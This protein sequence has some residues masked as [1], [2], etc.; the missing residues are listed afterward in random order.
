MRPLLA[1]RLSARASVTVTLRCCSTTTPTTSEDSAAAPSTATRSARQL[2]L[3]VVRPDLLDDWVPELNDVIAQE[4]SCNEATTPV[5]WRCSHCQERYQCT[6]QARV[7]RGRAACPRCGGRIR[8]TG[9]PS[10]NNSTSLSTAPLPRDEPA[11]C[12]D[13]G[14]MLDK[15]HPDLA[16][17][18]D[19]TRNGRLLPSQVTASSTRQVWWLPDASTAPPTSPSAQ[20][21]A[22]AQ[23]SF[24]RPVFAFV[25]DA[26]SP[27][28]Q[29]AATAAMEWRLLHE[30]RRVAHIEDAEKAG[31]IPIALPS[32]PVGTRQAA[33][34]LTGFD[35]ASDAV[36]RPPLAAPMAT[37][38]VHVV[39]CMWKDRISRL[40]LKEKITDGTSMQVSEPCLASI[41]PRELFSHSPTTTRQAGSSAHGAAA[42]AVREA[43]LSQY[44]EFV[45][46][47]R[48]RNGSSSS[49]KDRITV[50]PVL[51][52]LLQNCDSAST[53]ALTA[54]EGASSSWTDFFAL[55]RDAALPK[56][57]IDPA[58]SLYFPD[59]TKAVG[60]AE[61]DAAEVDSLRLTPSDVETTIT[62]VLTKYPRRPPSPRLREDDVMQATPPMMCTGVDNAED[63][64]SVDEAA[65][66][67]HLVKHRQRMRH[68]NVPFGHA[69][70]A[71]EESAARLAA[72][73]DVGEDNDDDHG[74]LK[75]DR[76]LAQTPRDAFSFAAELHAASRASTRATSGMGRR[77]GEAVTT[78]S[79]VDSAIAALGE[80][81]SA[82]VDSS[83]RHYHREA[84]RPEALRAEC[85]A[86]S[87]LSARRTGAS[88]RRFRLSPPHDASQRKQGH[89]VTGAVAADSIAVVQPAFFDAPQTPRKVARS[90]RVKKEV[91][92]AAAEV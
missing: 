76:G 91:S 27:E 5:W 53:D 81:F 47:Q 80:A 41:L 33:A 48:R 13:A 74:R 68:I 88:P 36:P 54:V 19:P 69:T 3:A 21:S 60:T 62:T 63:G 4:I 8:A 56:G 72:E 44:S 23:G 51:A 20:S 22:L 85:F 49:S 79:L 73:Y 65:S 42:S 55:T 43:L 71:A 25:Q 35:T 67:R 30:I 17:R 64:D 61:S 38:D 14:E 90:R 12:V 84:H 2:R 16:A 31:A 52:S 32:N 78:A 15:T 39:A 89:A 45:C 66:S 9:D 6:V 1:G 11:H 24:L 77:S 40:S 37:A 50:T 28:E 10:A 26:A 75:N 18:W 83:S 87:G 70:T 59:A 58:A 86:S 57:Y 29:A 46:L 34:W 82:E 7:A 92:S